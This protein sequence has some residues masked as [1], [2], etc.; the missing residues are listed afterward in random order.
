MSAPKTPCPVS[1]EQFRA[2]APRTVAVTIHGQSFAA[3]LKEFSTGSFGWYLN[4]KLSLAVDGVPCAV[5]IG[6]NLTVAN[7]K[8]A[9]PGSNGQP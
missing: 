1:R 5:Q 6:L 7:T 8:E 2:K 4:G 3:E 9:T